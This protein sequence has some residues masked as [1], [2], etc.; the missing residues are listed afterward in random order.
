MNDLGELRVSLGQSE[1]LAAGASSVSAGP[2]Q[3]PPPRSSRR[4]FLHGAALALGAAGSYGSVP[5]ALAKSGEAEG[6]KP[7]KISLAQPSLHKEYSASRL[8]P[9]DF[10]RTANGLG[11]DAVEYSSEFYKSKVRDKAFLA[12]LKR[13]AAGEGVCSLLIRVDAEGQLGAREPKARQ[14]AV[15]AHERWVEAAAVLGCHALCVGAD[16]HGGEDEQANWVSDGVRRLCEVSA[17]YA[18]DIL[19][20]NRGGL[21]AKGSWLAEVL[22]AVK[23][24]RCGSLPDFGNFELGGGREYDRY[25][26]VRELMPFAR[27]VSA[28]SYDFGAGG[29]ET[30][31]NYAL[32]LKIVTDAGYHGYVGIKYEGKR[33]SEH[34]GILRTKALLERVRVQLASRAQRRG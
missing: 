30:R 19:I 24:P 34:A 4:A 27:A 32:M 17:P 16:S 33:L 13:R 9:L 2:A 11:I 22:N 21:S 29:E 7:F 6:A 31:I 3:L 28:K 14:R 26:G 23:H 5:A 25:Q 8:D 12:E 10:A 20:E 18:V 15:D 1:A